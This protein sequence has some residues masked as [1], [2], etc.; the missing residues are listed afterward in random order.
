MKIF[1]CNVHPTIDGTWSDGRLVCDFQVIQGKLL[2]EKF[3]GA[4]AVGLPGIG[5][6]DDQSFISHCNKSKFIPIAAWLSCDRRQ[7]R[8]NIERLKIMGFCGVKIHPRMMGSM[9]SESELG[10]IFS[11]ANDTNLRVLFCTYP[12]HS[13]QNFNP[14][15]I[16][17]LL[18][19]A[20]KN[21]PNLPI[22]LMHSGGFELLRYIE[23]ARANPNVLLDLS[24]TLMKYAGSSVD[25]DIAFAFQNFDKR[26][27]IGS[28][29]PEYNFRDVRLRFEKFSFDL[30]EEKREN[31]A[32][33]NAFKFFNIEF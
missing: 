19:S 30:V 28:D 4:A 3:C 23:F 15:D 11:A 21:T 1:D 16:L 32:W 26:I 33:R 24:F 6:Y 2:D 31:I 25:L 17:S 5:S 7:V 22:M 29:Y 13:A 8:S 10:E 9:P 14:V 20:M 27:V 12:C 18:Q